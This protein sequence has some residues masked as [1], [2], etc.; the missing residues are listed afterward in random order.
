MYGANSPRNGCMNGAD[1]PRTD[2]C[3]GLTAPEG[4]NVRGR[5]SPN[6]RTVFFLNC[7][8]FKVFLFFMVAVPS[9]LG[10]SCFCQLAWV[11]DW[12]N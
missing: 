6:G 3:T 4:I 10:T 1:S 2:A 11:S 7:L 8:V 12:K 5:Q 9:V